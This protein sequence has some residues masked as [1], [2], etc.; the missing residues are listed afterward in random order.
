MSSETSP[1]I[2]TIDIREVFADKSPRIAKLL[3]GF[4]YRYLH[5]ILHID[6]INEVL[7]RYGHLKGIEFVD[8]VVEMFNVKEHL[9]GVENIPTSGK[10]IFA[11]NHPLGGFD[12]M[13]LMKNVDKKLGSFK[14]LANDILLNIPQLN[15]VFVPVNKHGAHAREAARALSG[16]YESDNQV[17]IFPS[18]LASRKIKGQIIDLEWKKHFISKA[19]QHHRDVIPVFISGRNTNRFYRL[20][21]LRKFFRIKWNLEMFFLPDETYRHRNADVHL[22]FGKPIPYTTFDESKTHQMWADWVKQKVYT[23]PK[24][25]K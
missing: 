23:L 1:A 3:P 6:F 17:L 20:A 11:S 21:K 19:I 16:V 7:V 13:L 4:V 14:F 12:G 24:E 25:I 10:Y 8:S 15:P 5:H 2:K 22:Y 18:G 9:H